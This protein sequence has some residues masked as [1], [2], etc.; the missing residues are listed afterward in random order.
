MASS[1]LPPSILAGTA[2]KK[3]RMLIARGLAPIPPGEML[4]LLVCLLKD[5]DPEVCDRAAQTIHG[6]AEAEILAEL[7]SPGCHASVLEYYASAAKSDVILQAIIANPASP[8]SLIS[9]LALTAPAQLLESILDNRVRILKSPEILESVRNNPAAS[10]EILRLAQEIEIEFLG[11]KK[12]EYAVEF[13]AEADT[14][15]EPLPNLE[16]EIPPRNLTLE[17]LPS[18]SD[19]RDSEILKRLASLP[20]RDK[21]KYALFGNREIRSVLVRD[22]NKEI[23]RAVL[24]SPSLRRTK[25]K[26]LRQCAVSQKI[27]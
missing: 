1:N 25:L 20:V 4:V 13:P 10:A 22:T 26:A 23:A 5:K 17:G 8:D 24:H 11:G 19:A 6:W 7:R 16:F 2:P 15:Q 3:M 21:I 9:S 14:P 27:Y 12:K 18:D